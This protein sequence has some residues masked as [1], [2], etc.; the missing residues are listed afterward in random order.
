MG[1]NTFSVGSLTALCL[2][3]PNL[4]IRTNRDF[5][6]PHLNGSGLEIGAL[7]APVG[8]LKSQARV[9]Y[10]DC[11]TTDALRRTFPDVKE[12]VNV[13]LVASAEELQSIPDD[14][15]DFI[16]A[17]HVIEH[18]V[19]PLGTLRV[20]RRKLRDGGMLFMAFPGG[21]FCPDRVRPVTPVEHLFDDYRA[22]RNRSVDEHVLS[23]V[24]AWNP[25]L[26]PD[27]DEMTRVLK[28]MWASG[29]LELDDAAIASLRRNENA[30]PEI[31]RKHRDDNI[32]QH[33]FSYESMIELL[34]RAYQEIDLRFRLVDL[35]LTK[36]CLSEYILLLEAEALGEHPTKFMTP[37]ALVAE[38]L[39]R[40]LET[41]IS[42][43]D[44]CLNAQRAA[45]SGLRGAGM[46]KWGRE[47]V[48]AI[49][50]RLPRLAGGRRV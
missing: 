13:A 46:M 9:V 42:E 45:L 43:K 3:M 48:N 23:F 19:N 4:D 30:V 28:T 17:N 27:P 10:V 14:S 25:G 6:A 47:R 38:R 37:R 39:E 16:I 18:L 7:D 15:L 32:H 26:F 31:L 49:R 2:H 20:W 24:L 34:Q 44:G 1:F 22:G 29:T 11:L 8:V 21:Q 41:W 35:S 33:V 12:L 5:Y 40:F 50:E 36:G